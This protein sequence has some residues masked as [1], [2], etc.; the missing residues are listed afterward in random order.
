MIWLWSGFVAIVIALLALDLGVFNRR[1]HE[2]GLREAAGWTAL[3][4]SVGLCFSGVIWFVYEQ[5]L[6]GITIHDDP[7]HLVKGGWQAALQYL[8][9]YVLEKSLSIDNIFV[10]A[11]LFSSFKV[12]PRY[13][14]RVLYL[15]ILGAV[16]TRGAMIFG[17]VWLV[18][19]FEWLFYVFGGYLAYAGVL[20]LLPGN[21]AHVGERWYV[22]WLQKV[23]PVSTGEHAGRFFVREQ[24]ALKVT[25]LLVALVSIELTDVV[26]AVDSVPAVLA[27]ST[28]PFIVLT[29]NIFAILGL[30]SLYFVLAHMLS[31]FEYLKYSLASIL[32]V[33]GAKMLL[34]QVYEMPTIWSLGLI[35]ALLAAGIV[36]SL[37]RGRTS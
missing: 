30:R 25:M 36:A 8:T 15:G 23:L 35:L 9:G 31:R 11:V 20:M 4:I 16:L 14:H 5:G 12:A 34:H 6:F 37:A 3:W 22:R 10:M 29:S 18:T 32:V 2:I 24:G 19:R 33:V 1:P 17:G 7:A 21:D 26:F 27:I 13:Q 28:D